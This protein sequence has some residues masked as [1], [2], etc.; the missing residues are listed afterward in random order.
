[1]SVPTTI[2]IDTSILD[3]QNYNFSSAAIS[4]FLETVKNKKITLLIP[5]PTLREIQ[6][7]IKERSE[8]I[9]KVLKDAERKAPF[10]KK[11]DS[12]PVKQDL[13]YRIQRMAEEEWQGFQKHFNVKIL[14]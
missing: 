13:L 11:W 14:G 4:A 12:W 9:I 3:E 1:M 2:F 7:H 5:D 8:D 6:R 10:L